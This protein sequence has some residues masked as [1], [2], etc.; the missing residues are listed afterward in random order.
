MRRFNET[1]LVCFLSLFLFNAL[2]AGSFSDVPKDHWAYEAIERAAKAGILNG[3]N[4]KFHGAKLLNRY[5]IAVITKKIL[6][7]VQD[8]EGTA[9]PQ[10]RKDLDKLMEE[11][12]GELALI[13]ARLDQHARRLDALEAANELSLL[14]EDKDEEKE[15]GLQ[16]HGALDLTYVNWERDG[17]YGGDSTFDVYELYLASSAKLNEEVSVYFEPR[18]EHAGDT[19]E[20]RQGYFDWNYSK[21]KA[22]RFG[23][24][25]MPF[26]AYRNFYYA[27]LRWTV[28]YPYVM[29][30]LALS[31]WPDVGLK[32][33]GKSKKFMYEFA[34]VN[35][36]DEDY[37]QEGTGRIRRA[38]GNRDNNNNKTMGGRIAHLGKNSEVGLSYNL[39]KYDDAAMYDLTN[40]AF[41]FRMTFDN[42]VQV[43][44]EWAK[45][46][47]EIA[48]GNVKT[49]GAFIH[50]AIP[51]M[52]SKVKS[53]C[54]R[55]V[56]FIM[57]YEWLNPG[58]LLDDRFTLQ[59]NQDLKA[60]SFG[61][62]IEP[63][64]HLLFK[65]EY[66]A[67]SED[68]PDLEND[69]FFIQSVIDF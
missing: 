9:P 14:S 16:F 51:I 31:P 25:Y 69:A 50:A 32:F 46:D 48:G 36:L 18:Y 8:K 55:S 47:A 56:K 5:Q 23:K 12:S 42:D 26:G 61:I 20:L 41:D 65:I 43:M 64:E 35:G 62:N 66:R 30:L 38:R 10:V 22:V 28:T 19:I 33:H 27:P 34:I 63:R 59:A 45:S 4:G 39:G 21:D 1:V 15:R 60:Y 3:Y 57:G 24:F 37:T 17:Q 58:Q 2:M 44:A 52:K 67:T 40:L 11:F 53:G 7:A 54:V 49:D 13:N 6:E 68:D 29:R